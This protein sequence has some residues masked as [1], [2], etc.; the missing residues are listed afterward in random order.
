[1][2]QYRIS[3]LNHH[4]G[5]NQEYPHES[6]RSLRSPLPASAISEDRLPFK[7][8]GFSIPC[9]RHPQRNEDSFLIEQQSGLVAALFWGG[10]AVGGAK[11]L[12]ASTRTTATGAIRAGPPLHKKS[13]RY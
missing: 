2:S 13:K 8:V 6:V 11:A 3:R 12:P 4:R 5:T 7:I 10:G 9:E 1:M